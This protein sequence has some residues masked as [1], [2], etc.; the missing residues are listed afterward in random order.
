ML[1]RRQF[2]ITRVTI[3]IKNT[4]IGVASNSQ[5]NY[6]IQANIGDTLH[7]SFIGL[8]IQNIPVKERN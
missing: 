2:G 1:C 6:T 7:F 8:E 3:R 4:N 5:G